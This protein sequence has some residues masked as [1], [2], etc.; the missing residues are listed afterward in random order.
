MKLNQE[1]KGRST[2][3]KQQARFASYDGPKSITKDDVLGYCCLLGLN[4]ERNG[5]VVGVEISGI[6]ATEDEAILR[7]FFRLDEIANESTK[8]SP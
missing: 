1:G 4:V 3:T 7:A 8:T 5:C 2:L 6:G